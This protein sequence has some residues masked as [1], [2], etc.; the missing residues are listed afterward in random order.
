MKK[1]FILPVL[2]VLA[3]GLTFSS[4]SNDDDE[5]IWDIMPE[6]IQI[7]VTDANGVDLINPNSP[8]SIADNGIKIEV[9][10]K[11]Y[12]KDSLPKYYSRAILAE[13]YGLKSAV[14]SD[15]RYVLSIGE[16]DRA[17][18]CDGKEILVDWNDG[19]K[20]DTLLFVNHIKWK[21]NEPRITTLVY[22]NGKETGS[23]MKIV[24]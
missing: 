23:S 24:K 17:V 1:L 11:V 15:G 14:R 6:E 3:F 10:G 16:F 20:K 19:S 18:N 8:N 9:D 12:E 2:T 4:C 22:L 5:L 13:F 21:H 7:E